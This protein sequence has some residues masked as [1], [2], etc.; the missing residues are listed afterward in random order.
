MSVGARAYKQGHE[1]ADVPGVVYMLC[2]RD[3][4]DNKAWFGH[5]GHYVGWSQNTDSRVAHHADGTGANLTALISALGLVIVVARTVPGTKQ[6]EYRIK[7]AG[8][9]TRYCPL[10]TEAP[11]LGVW[12]ERK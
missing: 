5:A 10:C 8:G 2:F 1:Y 6:D 3:A 11:R 7:S 4:D 9:Q 12:T